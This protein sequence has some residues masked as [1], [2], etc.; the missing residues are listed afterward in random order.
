VVAVSYSQVP[1]DTPFGKVTIAL[2]SM[3]VDHIPI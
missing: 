3:E 1:G 2:S